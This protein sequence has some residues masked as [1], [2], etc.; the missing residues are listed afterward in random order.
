M[1][2]E[3][4]DIFVG[5]ITIGAHLIVKKQYEN[6]KSS[7][8]L[9]GAPI[10]MQIES[11]LVNVFIGLNV[12]VGKRIL[13]IH[14]VSPLPNLKRKFT[15]ARRVSPVGD[16]LFLRFGERGYSIEALLYSLMKLPA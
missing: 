4:T 15:Y 3:L 10:N 5:S 7:R 2:L 8:P 1:A 13:R 12:F 9:F 14:F 11:K 6:L 16:S